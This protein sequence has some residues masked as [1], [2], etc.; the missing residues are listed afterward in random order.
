M[1]VTVLIPV[2]DAAPFVGE[3]VRSALAQ[4]HRDLRL[5]IAVEPGGAAAPHEPEASLAALR[6]FEAD[7]RVTLWANPARLGWTGNINRMLAAV[8]TPYFAILPHDDLW[9]PRYVET[10]LALLEDRPDAGAA[11]SDIRSFGDRRT[12][13]RAHPIRRDADRIGQIFDF[14]LEGPTGMPWRG[15]TRTATLSLTGGFPDWDELGMMAE[16]EYALRLVAAAP[17]LHHSGVLFAKRHHAGARKSASQERGAAALGERQAGFAGHW[18]KMGEVVERTVAASLGD[19]DTRLL[20]ALILARRGA[21]KL[22]VLKEALAASEIAALE[23][24][25]GEARELAGDGE[26]ERQAP[27]FGREAGRIAAIAHVTLSGHHRLLGALAAE[28]DHAATAYRLA[29]DDPDAG[30]AH[31]RI[32]VRQG[33]TLE[34]IEVLDRAHRSSAKPR[35]IERLLAGLVPAIR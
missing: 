23:W 11:Y 34:A 20:D 10:L 8:E 25:A 2:Y 5:V 17:V 30:F 32:L 19:A 4:T 9:H 14:F 35:H 13:R 12:W 33:R 7:P 22:T 16:T 27:R 31:G 28:R 24:A 3:T 18:L 21:G 6:E 26:G 15:L 29:P 1:S